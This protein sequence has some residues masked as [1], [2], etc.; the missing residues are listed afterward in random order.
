M[1]ILIHRSKVVL[2]SL[3]FAFLLTAMAWAK[4]DINKAS[5]EELTEL[6]G[7]GKTVAERIVAYREKNGPFKS[8]EDL[9][10]VKGIGEKRLQKILPLITIQSEKKAP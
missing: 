8:P 4:M 5:V 10:K 6:P 2:L 9:L 7:I 1:K 3:V